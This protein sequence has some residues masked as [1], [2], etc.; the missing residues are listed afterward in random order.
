M[1]SGLLQ[2]VLTRGMSFAEN[3]AGD[4]LGIDSIHKLAALGLFVLVPLNLYTLGVVWFFARDLQRAEPELWRQLV[5][6]QKGLFGSS[7][8]AIATFLSD[9]VFDQISSEELRE[10]ARKARVVHRLGSVFA[11]L[12]VGVFIILIFGSSFMR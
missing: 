9:G 11:A 7:T 4:K 1:D 8:R 10:A 6:R 12:W 5:I 2:L 3:Q